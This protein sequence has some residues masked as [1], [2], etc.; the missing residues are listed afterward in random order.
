LAR[1]ITSLS[2]E[3]LFSFSFWGNTYTI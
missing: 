3:A 1:P 2:K